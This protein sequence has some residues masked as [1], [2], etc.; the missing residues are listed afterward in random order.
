MTKTMIIVGMKKMIIWHWMMVIGEDD[1][2]NVKGDNHDDED[3]NNDGGN[4]SDDHDNDEDD[5]DEDGN[6]QCCCQ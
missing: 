1:N 3:V 2:E 6:W 4:D 5:N